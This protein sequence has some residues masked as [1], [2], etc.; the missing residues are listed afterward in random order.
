MVTCPLEADWDSVALKL[1]CCVSVS[2][3]SDSE[4]RNRIGRDAGSGSFCGVASVPPPRSMLHNRV[5]IPICFATFMLV[6]PCS[7]RFFVKA[8]A[9]W[10][11]LRFPSHPNTFGGHGCDAL[12]RAVCV[13]EIGA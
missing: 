6:S 9:L 12:F 10:L 4:K 2:L 3:R 1:T 8:C 13:E 7:M 5:M 11:A